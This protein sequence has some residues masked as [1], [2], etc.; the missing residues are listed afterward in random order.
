MPTLCE[1]TR[2]ITRVSDHLSSTRLD[3]ATDPS[4]LWL[5]PPEP[6]RQGGKKSVSNSTHIPPVELKKK[7]FPGSHLKGNKEKNDSPLFKGFGIRGLRSGNHIP[8][9]NRLI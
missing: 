1:C 4:E 5:N 6:Q 7:K 3:D 2:F 9:V 8:N